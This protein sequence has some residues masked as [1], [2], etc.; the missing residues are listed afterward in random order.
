MLQDIAKFSYVSS[1][2]HREPSLCVQDYVN[3]ME[4]LVRHWNI[5]SMQ[6]LSTEAQKAQEDVMSLLTRFKRLTER[7]AGIAKKKTPVMAPFS[8][9]FN[10]EVGVLP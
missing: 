3:I 6:G 1:S 4:F 10:K 7:Q 9:V 2:Q 5:S 8:W